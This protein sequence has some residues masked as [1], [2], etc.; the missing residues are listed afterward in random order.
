VPSRTEDRTTAASNDA[1]VEE[2]PSTVQLY[3]PST[4]HVLLEHV[5][6][7]DTVDGTVPARGV[8]EGGA[9]RLLGFDVLDGH[10]ARRTLPLRDRATAPADTVR[11]VE[12]RGSTK[13][14]LDVHAIISLPALAERT[15]LLE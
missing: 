11:V 6:I 14:G 1:G 7:Y 4:E 2:R 12:V 10:T 8:I 5:R 3:N 9:Q 13:R 15:A